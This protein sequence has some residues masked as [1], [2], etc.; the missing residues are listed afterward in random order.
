MLFHNFAAFS[1]RRTW[2]QPG[3]Q[4]KKNLDTA[5]YVIRSQDCQTTTSHAA[6]QFSNDL[7]CDPDP[8]SLQGTFKI[9][10]VVDIMVLSHLTT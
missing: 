6:N 9:T 3:G 10:D 1:L 2:K 4:A 8:F 7:Q 5:Q